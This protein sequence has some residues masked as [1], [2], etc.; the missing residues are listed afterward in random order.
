MSAHYWI[1]LPEQPVHEDTIV[2]S[3]VL[4]LLT[5]VKMWSVSPVTAT[6]AE[7]EQLPMVP[8]RQ[9]LPS[10][11]VSDPEHSMS[12]PCE[13]RPWA[14]ATTVAKYTSNRDKDSSHWKRKKQQDINKHHNICVMSIPLSQNGL[15]LQ[16]SSPL[17]QWGSTF[18]CHGNW[19]GH[20]ILKEEHLS[21]AKGWLWLCASLHLLREREGR[22]FSSSASSP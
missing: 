21:V 2:S 17:G 9:S 4:F 5:S 20:W 16:K 1:V 7:M 22:Q 12:F 19:P 15:L 13:R 14:E 8:A 6:L 3:T 18:S 11:S 10:L